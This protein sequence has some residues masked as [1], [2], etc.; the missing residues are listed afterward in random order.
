MAKLL[1]NEYSMISFSTYKNSKVNATTNILINL[2]SRG[3]SGSGSKEFV[4]TLTNN[5]LYIDAMGYNMIGQEE[6]FYTD[7][8]DRKDITSFEVK[9][10]GTKEL[11][12][13]LVKG[14]STEYIKNNEDS[15]NLASEMATL[16]NENKDNQ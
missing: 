6:I 16:I 8:L 14:K 10:E 3:I 2:I 4:L 12:I 5:N 11:I 1:D 9:K 15:T 7:K 13:L